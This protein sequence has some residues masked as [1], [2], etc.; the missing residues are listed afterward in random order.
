V[1]VGGSGRGLIFG[2]MVISEGNEGNDEKVQSG[3]LV[4]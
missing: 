2:V 1:E 3:C 4:S